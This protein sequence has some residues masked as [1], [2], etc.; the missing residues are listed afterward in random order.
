MTARLALVL[1][2][3][4]GVLLSAQ[5]APPATQQT[6]PTTQ[7]VE[8]YRLGP[9]IQAPVVLRSVQPKYPREALQAKIEGVV[10]LEL[11]ILADGTIG[12]VRVTKSLDKTNGLDQQAIDAAKQWLFRP[13]T[14][15][16]RDVSV[17]VTVIME[18]RLSDRGSPS[19]PSPTPAGAAA[20][21]EFYK[22][23]YP[24]VYPRLVQ[25][26]AIRTSQ[27][28]YTSEALR[29]KLQGMVEVE[30]VVGTD[31]TVTRARVSKSLDTQL[32]LDQ[33]ALD[34]VKSWTFEPG[35]LNGQPVPVVVT[36][37]LEFRIH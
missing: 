7:P 2:T 11:V 5:Q 34:A 21:D 27:P 31:G 19:T 29:A 1:A 23:T 37:T 30:A 10:E 28:K 13:G 20:S 22:D 9:G 18:F 12:D 16:G 32:G 33:N 6:P 36:L 8:P 25:P 15:D 4:F 35:R 17:I 3:S 14:R 24:S 26:V